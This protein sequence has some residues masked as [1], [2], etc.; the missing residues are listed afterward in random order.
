MAKEN[1]K[2][3]QIGHSYAMS[4]KIDVEVPESLTDK[5]DIIE[6]IKA[7][8]DEYPIHPID[9]DYIDGSYK[10]DIIY[11]PDGSDVDILD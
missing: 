4:G 8:E 1:T 11:W 2:F 5:E 3:I 7:H 6:Y 10:I 9:D